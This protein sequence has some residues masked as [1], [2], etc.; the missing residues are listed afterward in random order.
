MEVFALGLR[1][2]EEGA[3]AV[4][5]ALDKMRGSLKDTK[6][7]A[8]ELSKGFNGMRLSILGA[9]AA[10]AGVAGFGLAKMV[11]ASVEAQK[12]QALLTSAFKATEAGA[13]TSVE[14]LNAHAAA[15]QKISTFGD[16][17]INKAQARLL[18][19]TGVVGK[20]F[21]RATDVIVDFA[22]A[23]GQDLVQS[24]ESVGKALNFPSRGMAGLIKQGFI[25]TEAQQEQIKYFEETN[26]LAKAQAIILEELES[27]TKGAAAAQRDTLGGALTALQNAWSDLFEVSREK[28]AGIIKFIESITESIPKM[29]DYL[30]DLVLEWGILFVDIELGLAKMNRALAASN[31][32]IAGIVNKVSGGLLGGGLMAEQAARLAAAEADIVALEILKLD[33]QKELSAQVGNRTAP[34]ATSPARVP[35]VTP[36][37]VA[38]TKEELDAIQAVIDQHYKDAAAAFAFRMDQMQDEQDAVNEVIK[39]AERDAVEA[40]NNRMQAMIEQLEFQQGLRDT[41]A[42]GVAGSVVDGFAQGIEAAVA[43]GNIGEGFK[44]LTAA[45]LSGMGDALIS[46]G[47]ASLAGSALM[48]KIKAAFTSLNPSAMAGASVAMIAL[49]ATLKGAAGAAF[50][51]QRQ[52]GVGGGAFTPFGSDGGSGGDSTVTRLVF[53][54]TSA[55]MAAGMRPQPVT[56]VTVIGPNDPTAQRAIQELIANGSR[57]GGL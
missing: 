44:A 18:T 43:T 50:G 27:V 9:G 31:T 24:A 23:F 15:L 53:G 36:G 26:Q 21:T 48:A 2:K 52:Y 25:L 40:A 19:Y 35:L 45:I 16:E 30:S 14:A 41:L 12:N 5:T 7:D 6:K 34:E 29:R 55:G 4:K 49:G 17:E 13:W 39:Q 22:A 33:R 51:G 42:E 38:A 28:S 1:I 57:R 3:A 54:Q 8:D 10:I 56:H 37:D 47:T 11:S 20:E 46:F 32:F